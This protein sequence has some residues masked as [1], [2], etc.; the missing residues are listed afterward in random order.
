[1][2]DSWAAGAWTHTYVLSASQLQDAIGLLTVYTVKMLGN[3]LVDSGS[4]TQCVWDQN[5]SVYP[6]VAKQV[7]QKSKNMVQGLSETQCRWKNT[8]ILV[9]I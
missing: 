2:R 9:Q 1:M 4:K 6:T 3:Q 5:S 7:E 8:F